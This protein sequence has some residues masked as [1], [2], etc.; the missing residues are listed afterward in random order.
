MTSLRSFVDRTLS[1]VIPAKG[2]IQ[3]SRLGADG[4]RA[5]WIPASAGMTARGAAMTA[6]VGVFGWTA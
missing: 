5:H 6:L 1:F 3:G 2:G 4:K